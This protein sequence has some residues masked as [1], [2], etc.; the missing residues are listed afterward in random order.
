MAVASGACGRPPPASTFPSASAALDRMRATYA[1]S[2]GIRGD[3]KIDYF[4]DNGR[5]RGSVLYKSMLPDQL[6]FDVYSPFGVMLST[7]TSDG[8]NFTLFD[9]RQKQFLYGPADTPGR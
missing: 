2:R 6:R 8:Q 5:V 3:A 1:C 4:D 9:L 7:L